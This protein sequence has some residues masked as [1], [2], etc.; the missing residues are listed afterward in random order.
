VNL[1]PTGTYAL[2]KNIAEVTTS[3]FETDFQYTKQLQKN[4]TLWATLGLIWLNSKSSDTVPSFYISSHAKFQANFNVQYIQKRFAVSLNGLYKSRQ[5]Q[6]LASPVIAKVS[7]DYVVL[8]AK[9]E[10]FVWQNKASF[11]VEID[12]FLDRNY[13]DLLGSQMPGRWLMGGIKI[14]LTK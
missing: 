12:N 9:A 14:S 6:K 1:L 10:A 3:G 5:P 7:A 2:A 13:T 4:G 8:N 11:F